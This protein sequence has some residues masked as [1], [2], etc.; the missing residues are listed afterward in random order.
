M[1]TCNMY[2]CIHLHACIHQNVYIQHE[3]IYIYRCE[4][5]AQSIIQ[6]VY[7][8]RTCKSNFYRYHHNG[9]KYI[10][11]SIKCYHISLVIIT[12][13]ILI[14]ICII[15]MHAITIPLKNMFSIQCLL[16]FVS[17]GNGLG[18]QGAETAENLMA[19]CMIL[20]VPSCSH[21]TFTIMRGRKTHRINLLLPLS[22]YR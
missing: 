1:Y 13:I 10:M 5:H 2:I 18:L 16:S 20:Y 21:Q 12:F 22:P 9:E 8:L 17:L 15:S 4:Y 11:Y 3:Y 14:T 19:Y 6:Y 7:C